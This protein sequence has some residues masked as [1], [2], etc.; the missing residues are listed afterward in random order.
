MP[1]IVISEFMDQAAVAVC[2]ENDLP[3]VV[4]DMTVP[5]NIRKVVAY[6]LSNSFAEVLLIFGAMLLGWLV[7]GEAVDPFVILG[8]AMIIAAISYITWREAVLKRRRITPVVNETK[9]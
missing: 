8:G 5:G 2:R 4:F 3:I 6:T 9:V 1:D 7:F